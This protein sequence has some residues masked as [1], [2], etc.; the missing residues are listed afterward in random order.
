MTKHA[1]L[2]GLAVFALAAC[3]DP[4]QDK[5]KAETSEAK[6][7]ASAPAPAEAVRLAIEPATSK[8]EWTGSKVTAK[9]DGAFTSFRGNVALVAN[10][11]TKSSVTVEIDTDSLTTTPEGL[12]K[13][14]KSPDFFDVEKFPKASFASTSIA[15]GGDKGATHTVT[16]NLTFHGVTKSI[17]FPA[18]IRTTASSADVDAEFAINRKDFGLVYAGKADDLIRDDVVI[19]L[20]IRSQPKS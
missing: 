9:H 11:A 10:D 18:K 4:A 16:G 15:P 3:K 5:T 8:I 20:T 17:T 12:I 19:R 1:A 2:L 13:H 7:A 14:L 6:Q